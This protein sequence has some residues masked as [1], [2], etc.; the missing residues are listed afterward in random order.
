MHFVHRHRRVLPVAALTGFHPRA[1]IP[2]VGFA[3]GDDRS[4]P[5]AQLK[6]L[7]VGIGLEEDVAAVPVTDFVLVD[8][9][10][11]RDRG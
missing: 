1:I 9:A 10:R 8:M 11:I 6:S 5:R 4:G 7:S 3:R 2:G